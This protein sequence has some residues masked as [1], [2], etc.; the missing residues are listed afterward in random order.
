MACQPVE[1][2]VGF[3]SVN[4]EPPAVDRVGEDC[5]D[6]VVLA[7]PVEVEA[8]VDGVVEVE[9]E[10]EVD[11]DV[12]GEL[13]SSVAPCSSLQPEASAAVARSASPPAFS[14]VTDVRIESICPLLPLTHRSEPE[15]WHRGTPGARNL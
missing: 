14:F 11:V 15:T 3:G 6:V 7:P 8:E 13:V 5:P 1:F 10:F 2:S 12:T 4:P 9:V